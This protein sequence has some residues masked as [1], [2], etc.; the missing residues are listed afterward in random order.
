M[1]VEGIHLHENKACIIFIG[2][3]ASCLLKS[4][5]VGSV[6]AIYALKGAPCV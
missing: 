2:F 4:R 3:L 5:A 6:V 1:A